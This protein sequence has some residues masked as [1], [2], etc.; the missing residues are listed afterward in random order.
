MHQATKK[1]NEFFHRLSRFL[2]SLKE[3]APFYRQ[4]PFLLKSL[5][6]PDDADGLFVN[7]INFYGRFAFEFHLLDRLESGSV[8]QGRI[9]LENREFF[10]F[11]VT[12]V[13]A[14]TS[15]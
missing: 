2:P 9:V 4:I 15:R 11:R 14:M 3:V 13:V 10:P 12:S 5:A 6:Q 7:R 1:G 8:L